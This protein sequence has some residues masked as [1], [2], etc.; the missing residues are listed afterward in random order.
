M[1]KPS[2]GGER[3]PTCL[4]DA[5]EVH[6]LIEERSFIGGEWVSGNGTFPVYDPVTNQVIANVANMEMD[7]FRAAIDHAHEAFET[8][9]R[10][11]E[12]GRAAMLR[13]WATLIRKHSRDLSKLLTMENGKTLADAAAEVESSANMVSWFAE[14]AIRSYGD[15]IP[16]CFPNSTAVVLKQPIGVCGIIAPWNFPMAMITRKVAPAIAAGCTVVIKPPSET[17]LCALALTKLAGEAGIPVNVIQTVTT[18]NRAAVEELYTNPKVKKISFTG[19]TGVG[20]AIAE[21]AAKTMK[22]ISMELGGNASFI[23]FEDADLDDAVDALMGCKFRCSGQ[24]CICANRVFVQRMVADTFISKLSDRI[25]HDLKMGSGFD[26]S[27]TNGPLVNKAAVDKMHEL[28]NDAVLKGATV[29]AQGGGNETSET[30][31]AKGLLAAGNF[32]E[33]TLLTGITDEMMIAREEIFG[34]IAPVVVFD[35]EEDVVRLANNTEFGLA[36]YFFSN[37]HRRIWRVAEALQV[38]MVGVN[39]G[40]ISEAGSPFGGVKES[41][42]GKEGSKYG[43]AEYQVIKSVTLGGLA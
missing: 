9:S 29:V 39:T 7:D 31:A 19:S 30:A 36:S 23:V 17:P 21:K 27:V 24:T 22:K 37:D 40:K 34:P 32:V 43:L 16:S 11:K 1:E 15:I 35:R 18:R 41:G 10:T 2:H 6:D 38:G 8:F 28:I 42:Y 12:Y 3:H 13:K 25:R 20:K 26:P 14:E 5:L 4:R 33:P